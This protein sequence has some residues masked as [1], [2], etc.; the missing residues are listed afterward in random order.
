MC[1]L[2]GIFRFDDQPIAEGRLRALL[3]HLRHRGP[4][5]EAI[6]REGRCTLVHARLSILDPDKGRQ[7]MVAAESQSH[8]PLSVVFNGEIYNHRVLRKQLES[9]GHSFVSD[10]CD[11]E[12]ILFGYRQWGTDLPRRLDGMFAFA[13]WDRNERQLLLCRDRT[14]KKPLYVRWSPDRRELSFATLVGTL[15]AGLPEGEQMCVRRSSLLHYLRLGYTDHRSLIEGVEEVPAAHWMLI[16]E[17]RGVRS[18]NYWRPGVGPGN[19]SD[20]VEAARAMIDQAVKQRLEADVPLGC[21]LSGGID[22]SIIATLAQRELAARGEGALKTF[23]VAMPELDYDESMYATEVARHIGSNHR[24]LVADPNTDVVGD[25][26]RLVALTGEPTSD[27]SLLPTYWLSRATRKF[28]KVALSGDGGDELFAGYDR[29]RAM[30]LL[31]RHRWWLGKVPTRLFDDANPR[32][33]RTRLHRLVSAA[34]ECSPSRQYHLLIALFSEQQIRALG[35]DPKGEPPPLH[36]WPSEPIPE[37]AAMRWDMSH[38]LPFD[39][40]R[41]LDR[42]SMAMA[43]EVRC[44]MLDTKVCEMAARLPNSV[45]MPRGRPKTLLRQ[46]AAHLNLPSRIIRRP[47]RGFAVPIGRWFRGP[48]REP[49]RDCIFDTSLQS[50]SLDRRFVE[51]IFIEHE[52]KKMDHTHRLFALLTLSIWCRWLKHPTVPT[53]A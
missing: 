52:Q 47:K 28:V 5:G 24:T 39:L 20:T 16:D 12:V 1:G 41:K 48:L 36:D 21:F 11:T 4:D 30:R 37:T 10:H 23:S 14:G 53:V 19:N 27:S 42:A 34:A 46:V 45:L 33:T 17:D 7:P 29:Y 13:V 32:T 25:L 35:V 15:I 3:S 40:L 31:D 22:S 18:Q 26:Q 43:L 9:L 38:Y 2:A 49:L 8:G 44:P 51:K 6:T 50:L